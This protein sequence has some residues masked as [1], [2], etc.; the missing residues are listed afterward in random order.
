MKG[1]CVCT[2]CKKE[3]KNQRP[4]MFHLFLLECKFMWGDIDC[5]SNLLSITK[6]ILC[7]DFCS[8]IHYRPWLFPSFKVLF[9]IASVTGVKT[10][11]LLNTHRHISVKLF[12]SC[13]C[14]L[15]AIK[16]HQPEPV[17][18]LQAFVCTCD[19]VRV[20]L[21]DGGHTN[22]KCNWWYVVIA[23]L[24]FLWKIKL[25]KAAEWVESFI[26]RRILQV[27]L[28]HWVQHNT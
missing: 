23:G 10:T 16:Q 3:K 17:W 20:F 24:F 25:P 27:M 11:R 13:L 12:L 2:F 7:R 4:S 5:K 21:E 28:M 8:F 18:C 26:I 9:N 22:R 15:F 14:R 6:N 1:A 19:C